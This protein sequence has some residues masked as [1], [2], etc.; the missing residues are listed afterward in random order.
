[1]FTTLIPSVR[2]ATK[3][4]GIQTG[5]FAFSTTS[6]TMAGPTTEA[7]KVISE[8]AQAE[9]GPK[10][11]STSAQMQSQVGKVQVRMKHS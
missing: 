5:R 10:R 11:D 8:T 2:N 6:R 4:V 9:G 3:R 1:M 7:G